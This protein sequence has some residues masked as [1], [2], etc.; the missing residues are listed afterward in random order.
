MVY[1]NVSNNFPFR[2]IECIAALHSSIIY[3]ICGLIMHRTI[4][5]TPGFTSLSEQIYI[6]AQ[7][8]TIMIYNPKHLNCKSD[9]NESRE[10]LGMCV[11]HV[12]NQL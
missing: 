12:F 4:H 5:G 8:T 11:L 9:N 10:A 2:N 1:F 6:F 7:S 3:E